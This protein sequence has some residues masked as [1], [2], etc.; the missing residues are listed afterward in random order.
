MKQFKSPIKKY[1]EGNFKK[2][3]HPL[4]PSPKRQN[5]ETKAK[6]SSD[7]ISRCTYI[8]PLTNKRCR[9]K[10]GI[11]PEYC[12]LHTIAIQNV[13]IAPSQITKGGNGLFA[14]PFGFKKGDIIGR[15]NHKWNAVT[16]GKLE[17]RCNNNYCW[18]YVFCDDD[19]NKDYTKTKCWDGLDIRSTLMRNIN[20]AH[21]SKFKN[22]AI[23]DVIK[24]NVYVIA[25]KNIKPKSEIFVNYGK[26]YWN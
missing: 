25:S 3:K 18:S 4:S 14:G 26:Y 16:L 10:L 22:N 12:Y 7:H 24:G 6:K 23:F 5:Y 19:N 15:Y 13:Y 8:N 9:N 2:T 20:D 11:Y 21:G 17:K 1:Q